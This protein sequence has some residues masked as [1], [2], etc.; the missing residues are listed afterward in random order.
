V[1][2]CAGLCR[3]RIK[4]SCRTK[5]REAGRARTSW[6]KPGGERVCGLDAVHSRALGTCCLHRDPL[7]AKSVFGDS[8]RPPISQRVGLPAMPG[9]T[10]GEGVDR[11]VLPATQTQTDTR[12]GYNRPW[13]T[14]L[15]VHRAPIGL[16]ASN[17]GAGDVSARAV[18]ADGGP[19]AKGNEVSGGPGPGIKAREV[20]EGQDKVKCCS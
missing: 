2:V 15:Y 9:E 1:I 10:A 14:I 8:Y 7:D 4:F 13:K 16:C 19:E 17:I 11:S 5:R 12:T 6:C 18:H 20:R 3:G